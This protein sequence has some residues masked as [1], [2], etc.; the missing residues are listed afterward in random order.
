MEIGNNSSDMRVLDASVNLK[1]HLSILNSMMGFPALAEMIADQ[2]ANES[3][4]INRLSGR[5]HAYTAIAI[6]QYYAGKY[7]KSLQNAFSVYKLA[8]QLDLT[9]WAS[10]LDIVIAR[11]YLVMGELDESWA[12]PSPRH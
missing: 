9:W 8:E 7:Q 6:A 11:N 4:L 3:K 2:A 5:V 12:S 10:L 1:S